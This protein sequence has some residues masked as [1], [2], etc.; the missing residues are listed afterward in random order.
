MLKHIKILI[1]S[2]LIGFSKIYAQDTAK[3]RQTANDASSGRE[4][5]YVLMELVNLL[6]ETDTTQA[7][8]VLREE[9]FPLTKGEPYLEGIYYF[10]KAGVYFDHNHQKS[11]KFYQKANDYLKWYNTSEAYRYRARLWHNYGVLEQYNGREHNLLDIT[12]KYCIPYAEKS[13]DSDLLMEY[14]TD[15]GMLLSNNKEYDRALEYYQKSLAQAQKENK[16]NEALLWTYLNMFDVYLK[17]K[18]E[19]DISNLYNKTVSLWKQYPKSKLT[20]FVYLNEAR[21]FAAIGKTEE[22]LE[23]I[24][25]G[26]EFASKNNV[27][28]DQNSLEY[29][30]V[31][32]L[33]A[34]NRFTEAKQ[35]IQKLLKTSIN[36]RIKNNQLNLIYY[37]AHL[38]A[39]LDNYQ[40]A[41]DLMV[42]HSSL[43]D[44]IVEEKNKRMFADMEL[45]YRTAEKEKAILQLENKNKLNQILLFFGIS[46]LGIVVAWTVYARN[47][48]QRRRKKDFMLRK[49]QQEIEITHA[50]MEGEQQERNRLARELHDGLGGRIT[51]I[52]MN[53]ETLSQN[54]EQKEKLQ[55]IVKQLDIAIVELRNTAHN[56]DPSSLQK[57]GLQTAITDFCQYLQCEKHHIK[58][59]TNGLSDLHNKKWQLSV[60]RIVQELLTNAVK[61]AQ[62]SEIQLQVTF[63]DRLLLIE[64]EDNGK[65]FDPK[66]VSRN[67]GLNNIETRVSY[68]GGKMEIYSEE[69]AGTT[70]N[71][72][73]KI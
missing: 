28:W 57:Y 11:Q 31:R 35:N 48:R 50:L 12:L 65:G 42:K 40:S 19:T 6:S 5:F 18:D 73:C 46:I 22:A 41:Y 58:L 55:K 53:V 36:K 66:S 15:I 71:I 70:I 63:K 49:Q 30:K 69:G 4:K 27:P 32:I 60:Y 16:E 13:G 20:G 45:Q 72:E 61:H 3:L 8:K 43:K 56:L 44:S 67:M 29:E 62:A 64:V 37:L 14:F 47:V 24:N 39:N 7:L 59:Y 23:S 1:L 2:I 33:R 52:K 10:N 68:L 26:L 34:L 38:E 9:A 54:S 17:K 25:K 21:Y 51:G